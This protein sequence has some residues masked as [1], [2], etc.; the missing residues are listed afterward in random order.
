MDRT[1]FPVIF[2]NFFRIF[3]NAIMFR[4]LHIA[5]TNKRIQRLSLPIPRE[6]GNWI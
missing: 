6:R 3:T 4:L 2:S 5:K 1:S